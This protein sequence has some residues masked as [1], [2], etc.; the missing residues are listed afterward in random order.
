VPIKILGFALGDSF[1]SIAK[2]GS[3]IFVTSLLGAPLLGPYAHSLCT[4]VDESAHTFVPTGIDA[5]GTL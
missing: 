5:T 3:V 2:K 1:P 4:I